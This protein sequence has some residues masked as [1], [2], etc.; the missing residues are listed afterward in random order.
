MIVDRAHPH[1]GT[2]GYV[3]F[4]D[5]GECDAITIPGGSEKLVK[6]N[7]DS[8]NTYTDACY[9]AVRQLRIQPDRRKQ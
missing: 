3:E 9:A 8:N 4:D 5:N 7:L 6:V 1:C 2:G